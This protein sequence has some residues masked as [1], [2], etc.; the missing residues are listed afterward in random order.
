MTVPRRGNCHLSSTFS[1]QVG[2]SLYCAVPFLPVF[3]SGDIYRMNRPD[4]LTAM[5]LYLQRLPFH[6]EA[7]MPFYGSELLFPTATLRH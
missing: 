3:L 6:R 1:M 4:R 7:S 2:R 5:A